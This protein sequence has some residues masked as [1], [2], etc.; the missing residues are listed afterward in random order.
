MGTLN[1]Y[2]FV[3]NVIVLLKYNTGGISVT[4]AE[5]SDASDF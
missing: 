4:F 2:M 5:C 3:F 1:T